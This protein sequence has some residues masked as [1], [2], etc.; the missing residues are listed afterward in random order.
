VSRNYP[1]SGSR[2]GRVSFRLE[3]FPI[4]LPETGLLRSIPHTLPCRFCR[5]AINAPGIGHQPGD[6]S[7][8]AGNDDFFSLF[9][10][11]QQRTQFVLRL[12]CPNFNHG[13]SI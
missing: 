1:G 7:A 8:M 10:P 3:G 11:V 9:Y 13:L 4:K 6:R 2:P 12:E 5:R